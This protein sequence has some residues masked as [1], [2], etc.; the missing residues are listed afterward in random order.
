MMRSA[1]LSAA[2]HPKV[3]TSAPEELLICFLE[4]SMSFFFFLEKLV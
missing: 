4:V 1:V 2:C 3:S